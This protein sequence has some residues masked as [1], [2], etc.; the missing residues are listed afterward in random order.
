MSDAV[1]ADDNVFGN[2]DTKTILAEPRT[3]LREG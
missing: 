2:F 1:D 3:P